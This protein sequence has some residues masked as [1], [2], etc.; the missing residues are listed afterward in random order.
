[1]MEVDLAL[2]DCDWFRAGGTA[3]LHQRHKDRTIE[4]NS[5][6]LYNTYVV[7]G[8]VLKCILIYILLF[9]VL[10]LFGR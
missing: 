4:T 2:V 3:G 7:S 8:T 1:M 5:Q 9:S 10:L 6:I